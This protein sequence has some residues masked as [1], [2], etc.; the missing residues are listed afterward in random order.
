MRA[1]AQTESV[2][3]F[4]QTSLQPLCNWQVRPLWP[5]SRTSTEEKRVTRQTFS[6]CSRKSRSK[7][8]IAF[9]QRLSSHNFTISALYHLGVPHSGLRGTCISTPPPPSLHPKAR[10]RNKDPS[11]TPNIAGAAER[12]PVAYASSYH[13]PFRRCAI[14]I[15][16]C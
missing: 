12:P 13:L 6:L 7:L 1:T 16:P 10:G 5:R 4:R 8:L 9:M 14:G 11:G 3:T 2:A 15:A